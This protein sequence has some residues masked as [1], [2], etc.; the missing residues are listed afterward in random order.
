MNENE[1]ALSYMD[2]ITEEQFREFMDMLRSG[3]YAAY[4]DTGIHI[5][6]I[7]N[8]AKTFTVM[9]ALVMNT[10]RKELVKKFYGE[11]A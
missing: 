6:N 9:D 3:K 1:L 4:G 11:S 10:Y 7:G 5:Q 2:N 8:S